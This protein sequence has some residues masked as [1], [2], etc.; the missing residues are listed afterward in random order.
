MKRA[1]NSGDAIKLDVGGKHFHVAASTLV[2]MA[3][4]EPLVKGRF[5]W[6]VGESG[7][8]FIDRDGDLF[9]TILQA[10]RTGQRPDQQVIATRQ[11]SLLSECA[12][13]GADDVA[14]LILGE[15][16]ARQLRPEDREIREEEM[17]GDVSLIDALGVAFAKHTPEELLLPL[18]LRPEELLAPEPCTSLSRFEDRLGKICGAAVFDALMGIPDIV[19]AGSAV[20]AALL[21]GDFLPSDLDMFIIGDAGKGEGV[22]SLIYAAVQQSIASD[23]GRL[24]VTRSNAAVTFFRNDGLPV[25]LVLHVYDDIASLLQGFDVDCVVRVRLLFRF[26]GPI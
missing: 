14:S 26:V 5:E 23:K 10:H 3:F 13:Y 19:F 8:F 17:A 11:A 1:R 22:F 2:G 7:H 25:Q 20:L 12:Y 18:L 16:I 24:L 21:E 15:T 9:G 6:D 4:F